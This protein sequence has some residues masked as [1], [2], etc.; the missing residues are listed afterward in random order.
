[1]CPGDSFFVF[2]S[3]EGAGGGTVIVT[4][5]VAVVMLLAATARS[6]FG[7]GEALIAVPLLT[8]AIPVETAAPVAVLCS[9]VVATVVVLQDWRHVHVRS[10]GR[11]VLSTL[12]GLP[13]GLLLLKTASAAVIKGALGGLIVAFSAYSLL[14]RR[15]LELRDD[16]FAWVFGFAAGVLGGAYGINGPPLA[17]YGALRGWSPEKFR[18]TL[19]GYFLPASLAGMCGYGAAGLWTHAVD[20]LFLWSLPSVIAGVFIGRAINRRLDARRFVRGLHV[21]L[22]SIGLVLLLQTV[23]AR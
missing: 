3:F 22:G 8:L 1:M 15:N 17:A 16:R 21:G 5:E 20:R 11:L 23:I 19:Q 6:A 10:A 13:L 14:H 9:I 2:H 7:F 4:A 12:F 18:A